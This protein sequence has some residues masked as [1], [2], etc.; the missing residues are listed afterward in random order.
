MSLTLP[1]SKPSP[2]PEVQRD[3]QVVALSI[4]GRDDLDRIFESGYFRDLQDAY[5]FAVAAALAKSLPPASSKNRTTFVNVGGLDPDGTLRLAVQQLRP[6]NP[7]TYALIED[8][9]EAGLA[10]MAEHL[11]QGRPLGEYLVD[12]DT[13]LELAT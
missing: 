12:L 6:H 10:D 8:L 9:G 3:K 11:R 7:R 4:Q 13:E 1:V 5:R 2:L